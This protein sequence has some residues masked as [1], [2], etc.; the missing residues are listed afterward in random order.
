MTPTESVT[1]PPATKPSLPWSQIAWFGVLLLVCYAP[2]L[3]RMGNDWMIDEDMGH[4]FFVPAVSLYLVWIRREELAARTYEPFLPG[5]ALVLLGGFQLFAATLGVELFL[6]RTAF[7]VSLAG[8]V[9]TLG[10]VKL[11]RDLAF[12]LFLL[13]FMVPLPSI[14]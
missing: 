1:V 3:L 5:L 13:V 9:L 14:I 6:A 10:G 11:V 2:V 7:I 12:P 4:G 8:A